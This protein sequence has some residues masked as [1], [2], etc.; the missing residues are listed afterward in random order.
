MT[1]TIIERHTLT[2]WKTCPCC[3]TRH[4]ILFKCT[5]NEYIDYSINYNGQE[6]NKPIQSIFPQLDKK[7]LEFLKS[8]TCKQCQKEIF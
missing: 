1:T 5:D 8:G 3:N 2:V 4:Y 6:K 7:R